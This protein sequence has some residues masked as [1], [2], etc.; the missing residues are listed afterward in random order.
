MN[1]VTTLPSDLVMART[2]V[3]SDKTNNKIAKL[4][5]AVR[6]CGGYIV[7][8]FNR[9]DSPELKLMSED[10]YILPPFLKPCEPV[11]GSDTRYLIQFHT[12]IVNFLKKPLNIELCNEKLFGTTPPTFSPSFKHD[13]VILSFPL[14]IRT[15]FLSLSNLHH[16]TN[17]SPPLPLL[18]N[19]DNDDCSPLTPTAL[20]KSLFHSEDLVFYSIYSRGYT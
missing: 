11:D 12:P 15:P 1:I 17:T 6:G 16:E 4:C 5:Y 2:T 8:K 3:Q 10:L 19:V 14:A 7:R 18:E 13:H 20:H 9:P